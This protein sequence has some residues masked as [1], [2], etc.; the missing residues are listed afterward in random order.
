[1]ATKNV[2]KL[3]PK[4]IQFSKII[5]PSFIIL[6]FGLGSGELILWPYL[7][8]NYGLGI[9]WAALLGISC[10]Y[11]INMEIERY[12][13]VRGESVFVGLSRYLPWITYWFI[14]STFIG[15]GLPGIIAAA[16]QSLSFA[17]GFEEYTW[18][19]IG[20]LIIFGLILSFGK[21]VYSLM[22]HLTKIV[23]LSSVAIL[24]VLVIL[25]VRIEHLALF[26]Q[27]LQGIGGDYLFL[28]AGISLA[29]FLAAFAY[30]GAGGN[31]NLAQ[32]IYIKEKG[33]GMGA[34]SQKIGGLFRGG[35][36][37][38]S[39]QLTGERFA[40]TSENKK[41][42]KQW[43]RK[44]SLEHALVFWFVGFVAMALLM[45][46][47]YA[48]SFGAGDNEQGIAFLRNQ[49]NHISLLLGIPFGLLFLGIVGILLSQTQLGI[50]DSTSR[51][52]A[53]NTALIARRHN[54]EKPIHLGKIYYI[55]VWSQIV[56]GI[57][58][59]LLNFKEPRQLI[60]LGAVINAW[61]MIV[62]IALV[63]YLNH[64]ELEKEFRP[65][66]WRKLVLVIIFLIFLGFGGVTIWSNFF[67][68]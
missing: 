27:G 58:L 39:V 20:L 64:K 37:E 25:I 28:P 41:R 3:F 52:M 15:F 63:F 67:T 49:S 11:F 54:T 53:E 14:I 56:F 24:L 22:E 29:T 61:A 42:F 21:T 66:L 33:Y 60:V 43:W 9:V 47:A 8:A 44:I 12:A 48:A 38:A 34:Y 32:S 1:M 26:W 57:I 65:P 68:S 50:L 46:L 45:M 16:A 18:L 5:G 40:L 36:I 10:Q 17:F 55:F 30:S 59:F 13:L 6:A 62:H 4:P 31:L 19:A 7:T 51:I 23:I 2:T 35:K